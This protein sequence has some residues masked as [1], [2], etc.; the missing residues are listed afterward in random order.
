MKETNNNI[1]TDKHIE[2]IMT[3]FDSK[4]D[5]EYVAKTVENEEIAKEDYGLSVS[6]YVEA[7]D[8]REVIDI[9]VLNA[10]IKASVSKIDLLRSEIDKI[11]ADIEGA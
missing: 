6:T 10:E 3:M 4:E 11:V 9:K 7:K 2:E 1:L 5:I 8:T